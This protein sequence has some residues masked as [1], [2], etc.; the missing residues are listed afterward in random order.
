MHFALIP[1]ALGFAHSF[2]SRHSPFGINELYPVGQLQ[3]NPPGIFTQ[4]AFAAH[5]LLTHSSTTEFMI[6]RF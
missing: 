5:G 4:F 2:M 6:C 1:Q 3:L